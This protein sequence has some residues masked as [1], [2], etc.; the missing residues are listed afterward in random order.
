[1][2]KSYKIFFLQNPLRDRNKSQHQLI[3]PHGRQPRKEKIL[4]LTLAE[5]A[6]VLAHHRMHVS[7]AVTIGTGNS[8]FRDVG[9]HFDNG[10]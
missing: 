6:T 1:M 2:N 10:S 9:D 5:H 4:P 7:I 3:D 8:V